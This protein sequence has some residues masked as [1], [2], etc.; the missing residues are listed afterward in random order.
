MPENTIGVF[1]I[2]EG[3]GQREG[4]EQ[5]QSP[6]SLPCCHVRHDNCNDANRTITFDRHREA[7]VKSDDSL[8][9]AGDKMTNAKMARTFQ[10]IADDGP[11]AF[12][13]GSLTRDIVD[14][15]Q[16]AGEQIRHTNDVS[17]IDVQQLLYQES[18]TKK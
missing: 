14:D 16:E 8:Y 4:W 10:A 6:I 1:R 13:R 5:A 9:E 3:V 15:I 7:Y 17:S 11:D 12:Y 18:L 2:S